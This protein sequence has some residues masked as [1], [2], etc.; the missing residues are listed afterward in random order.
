MC[1]QKR[2]YCVWVLVLLL[3]LSSLACI[4]SEIGVKVVQKQEGQG[5][6]T[7][8][9]AMH[10]TD[11]YVQAARSAN[12]ERAQDY[13]AA[14]LEMPEELFPETFQELD[15]FGLSSGEFLGEAA[16]TQ[17]V[18]QSDRGFTLVASRAFNESELDQLNSEG[19]VVEVNRDDPEWILYAVSIEIED[20]SADMDLSE[21]DQLRAEGLGPKPPIYPA[22]EPSE[23]EGEGLGTFIV[24]DI[25]ED[26]FGSLPS[27]G[28]ELDAWYASRVLLESGWPVISYWVELPG[29]IRSH[30][31]NGQPAGIVDVGINR[32]TLVIDEAYLRQHPEGMGGV[33]RVESVVHVCEEQCSAEPHQAWS[34]MGGPEECICVCEPGWEWNEAGDACVEAKR[35]PPD[36]FIGNPANLEAM[37]RALGYSEAHCPADGTY[38]PGSVFLW[39]RGAGIAHSS[40]MTEG[41]QHIEMGHKSG[42]S[43]Y[44]SARL[45]PRETP[46]PFQGIYTV[47]QVL[48]R[49]P[50]ARFDSA[51]ASTMAGLDR[52]YG[53]GKPDEWNCHGF[54]ANVVNQYARTGIDIRPGSQY[55]WEGNKLILEQGEIHIRD[56]KDIQVQVINGRVI[57]HSEFVAVAR[58][59]GTAQIAVLEGEVTFEGAGQPVTVRSNQVSEVDADGRPSAPVDLARGNIEAWWA[60]EELIQLLG[61]E[62]SL[63]DFRAYEL[64]ETEEPPVAESAE[65]ESDSLMRTLLIVAVV[66]V[67]GGLLLVIGGVVVWRLAKRRKIPAPSP[68][69]PAQPVAQSVSPYSQMEQRFA[70]LQA[71][72]RSGRLDRT[73]FQA[74]VQKLVM[75]DERGDYWALSGEGGLWYWYDGRAWVRRDPLR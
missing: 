66:L 73:A 49:P 54:S 21:L 26:L 45:A 70:V 23:P 30:D 40:V 55:R 38:P 44:V 17:I 48:C 46:V 4:T 20:M 58:G 60:S 15:E 33:W 37:L 14:G 65:G 62:P 71:D 57:H 32:V 6:M 64:G 56:N 35:K 42:G 63:A 2:L 50:G 7:G 61:P 41:D 69:Q 9:V 75:R 27:E 22:E 31:M 72:Y 18:E 8:R 11:Q 13:Q 59:D 28:V 74:A 29:E 24:T 34:E 36:H 10:L 16:E 43:K 1:R 67:G 3:G 52:N 25:L 39:N 19:L 51:G 5:E 53:K 12:A 68:A 47:N